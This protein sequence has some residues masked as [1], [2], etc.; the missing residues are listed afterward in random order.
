MLI[1]TMAEALVLAAILM[2][3]GVVVG[4]LIAW[5]R[6]Q[7]LRDWERAWRRLK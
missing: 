7:A 1:A 5:S 4:I 6:P 3:A 2:A